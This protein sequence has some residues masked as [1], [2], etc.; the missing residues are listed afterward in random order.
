MN[1]QQWQVWY[2]A[3]VGVQSALDR[4]VQLLEDINDKTPEIDKFQCEQSSD[5]KRYDL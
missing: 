3:S 1:E 5:E 4:I 2:Q